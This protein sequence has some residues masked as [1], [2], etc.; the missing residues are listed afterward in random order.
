MDL[1]IKVLSAGVLFFLGQIMFAQKIQRDTATSTKNI[2]EVVVTG[3]QKK[4]QATVSQAISVVSGD[5]LK[6]NAPTTSIGNA[7]Q[8]KAAGVFV[9][10]YT[11]QPGSTATI[12][13]RGVGG[14]GGSSEPAY[15]VNGMYMT[16]RQFSA[17]NPADVESISILKDAA[18]TSIYGARGS[19][20]VV[21]VTTKSGA[22]MKT[23]FFVESK[24]GYSEK[25][26]DNNFSMM[27]ANELLNFQNKLGFLGF[28]QRSKQEIDRLALYNHNWQNTLLRN[29]AVQ[30]FL[31]TAQ[32]GSNKNTFY[33]SLGYDSDT[34]IL[35]DVKGIDRYTGTFNFSNQ[36]TKK[37]KVGVNLGF[38]F[39]ETN[40][41]LDRFN[42]QNPFAAMYMYAPFEPV[43]NS[44]GSYNQTMSAGSNVVE[45]IRTYTMNEK[46][47][48]LPAT[49]YGE[50]KIFDD[51]K[52]KTTFNGLYDWYYAK[53]KI[54]KGSTLDLVLYGKPTGSLSTNSFY[55]FNYTFNNS[56]N[57]H[58]NIGEHTID[59]LAFTEFNRNFVETL[60]ASAIGFKSPNLDVPDNTLPSDRSRY[61]GKKTISSLMSYAGILNYDYAK[62]YIVSGSIRRDGSSKFG[63]NNKYGTFWSVSGAWNIA[64]EEFFKTDLFNDLK[65]RVSYGTTGNDAN[66]IE[67]V[68]VSNVSY[69]IYGTYPTLYPFRDTNNNNI[70]GNTN[71]KWETNKITGLGVDFSLMRRRLRGAVEVYQ[72]K[73][74]DFIQLLPF[75]D[76]EGG[77]SAYTNAGNITQKGLEVQVSADI[78]K[79]KDLSWALRANSS[80]QKSRL[81]K[82]ADGERERYLGYTNL[83]VGEAPYTFYNVRFAGVNPETGAAQYYTKSGEITTTYNPADA[84]LLKGKTPFPKAFG[85]F[86]TSFKYKGFDLDADFVFKLGGYTYNNMWQMAVDPDFAV[87][88]WNVAKEAANFWQAPGDNGVFQRIN[89]G[90]GGIKDSDQFIEKND[91]LRFRTL[92]LGYTFDKSF[93]GEGAPVNKMRV[94]IQGQNLVTWTK[95]HGEPEVSLGSADAP[96]LFVPGA[97]N[98]YT[99]PMTKTVLMGIQLDF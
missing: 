10:S 67:Y 13:V 91:Y 34:G 1:K 28:Q 89:N 90:G 57:Y 87:R 48:R 51:L 96:M 62:K 35:K 84:V 69:G 97:Y 40:N 76:D 16:A 60:N 98:L 64:Q 47:F 45:Q 88:G 26:K 70:Q 5:Q 25:L 32:G 42:S 33:Y 46:R 29:S 8:G 66:I 9:Q 14:V 3:Y 86:G 2:E 27:N 15:I 39:Q 19:N 73:R 94:Y 36:L 85:G 44:D 58:K 92:T 7:V 56:L 23:V 24:Y 41:F 71:V 11:G 37:L 72:N 55:T 52:F 95:F 81:D 21:V 38:Q 99:Y 82:L 80:W 75:S 53:N 83:A 61:T 63:E 12:L 74:K 78:I 59:V 93:L 54:S 4:K 22:N 43:Y 68:N 50:Y 65:L 17:I 31:L 6:Q 18:A 77:Y 20:G 79:T 30:S 49:V